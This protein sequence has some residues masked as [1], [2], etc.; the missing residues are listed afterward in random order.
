M[1]YLSPLQLSLPIFATPNEEHIFQQKSGYL[2]TPSSCLILSQSSLEM[3]MALVMHLLSLP[4]A[5]S[6]AVPVNDSAAL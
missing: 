1:V 2:E 5:P 6:W 3:L 4:C